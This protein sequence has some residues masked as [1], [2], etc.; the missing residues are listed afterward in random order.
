MKLQNELVFTDRKDVYATSNVI[1]EKLEVDHA[2]LLRTIEKLISELDLKQSADQ[3]TV[4][5]EVISG[6]KFK[7]STFVNKMNREYEMWCMNEQGFS[8]LVMQLW[9]YEKAREIQ[10]MFVRAF[11]QMKETLMNYQN[12]SWISKRSEVKQVR[13]DETDVIKEFVEYATLQGSQSAQMYYMNITKM[14][15]KALELLIQCKDGKPIR[16]LASVI[17]LGFIQI[18]DYR[19]S[20][21]IEDGMQRKLPYKEVYRYAKEEVNK[22]VS[23]LD[24]T[25][26]IS[27]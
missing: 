26:G 7:K 8:L 1:A 23:A 17:Q 22:L 10:L 18:V 12:A 24:F 9:R 4:L 14:T 19:A 5:H 20:Q 15:N 21:A 3:R 13:Q 11:F 25:K 2:D 6:A 27:K 16:D